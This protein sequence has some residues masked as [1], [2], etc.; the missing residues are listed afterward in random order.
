M[1]DTANLEQRPVMTP[2]GVGELKKYIT[3][4][5]SGAVV[6]AF[7]KIDGIKFFCKYKIEELEEIDD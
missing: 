2:D 7:V 3:D 5:A 1:I 4:Y 6:A